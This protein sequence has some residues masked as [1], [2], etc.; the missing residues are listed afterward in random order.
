MA[1]NMAA[2]KFCCVT[3]CVYESDDFDRD[4]S[5]DLGAKWTETAGDWSIDTNRLKIVATADAKVE[6][7]TEHPTASTKYIVSVSV[8]LGT[9]GDIARVWVDDSAFFAELERITS[10]CGRLRLYKNTTCKGSCNVALGGYTR[11]VLCSE[12]DKV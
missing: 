4:D 6:C 1:C 8:T 11:L 7:T 3:G 5:T 10:T 2:F 12:G 9:D